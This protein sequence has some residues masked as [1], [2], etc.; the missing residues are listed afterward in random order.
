MK[1]RGCEGVGQHRELGR[2][3]EEDMAL[4]RLECQGHGRRENRGTAK[5]RA[6][7][8]PS[9]RTGPE[10]VNDSAASVEAGTCRPTTIR[11]KLKPQSKVDGCIVIS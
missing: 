9:M 6:R 4:R 11:D 2:N 8:R 7:A 10:E 3:V 1:V 5:L